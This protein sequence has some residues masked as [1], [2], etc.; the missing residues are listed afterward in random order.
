MV[1][2]LLVAIGLSTLFWAWQ[3][4]LDEPQ[5]RAIL[6]GVT[7]T[8]NLF[9]IFGRA[10]F[11]AIDHLWVMA[12]IVQFSLLVPV[13]VLGARRFFSADRRAAAVLGL[14][15]GVAVC[16]LGFLLSGIAEHSSIAI[17]TFTRTD[18]LLVGVAIGVAPLAT[19]RRQVPI[20]LAPPAFAMML[21][22]LLAAP[23]QAEM[24]T[25]ALG[26]LT[27]AMV[28]FAGV[29]ASWEATGGPNGALSA[30]LDNQFM[31]WIGQR[32]ISLY[33]WHHIF[34][35]ALDG[36]GLGPSEPIQDWPGFALFTV[37]IVFALAAAT[38]SYRYLELPTVAIVEERL[39]HVSNR[40][41][42]SGGEPTGPRQTVRSV[43]EP[44]SLSGRSRQD[45]PT[46]ATD[47]SGG[48]MT[49]G[50]QRPR[51]KQHPGLPGTGPRSA[52]PR[53]GR[54]PVSPMES[55]C[56]LTTAPPSILRT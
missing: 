18:A 41:G 47:R 55:F 32:A 14:A 31:K 27:A 4:Q 50:S 53:G 40:P 24:P 42:S 9:A 17:N 1:T 8:F 19:V 3:D 34:G 49:D 35:F 36:E 51:R 26:I 43:T 7:S 38:A 10:E 11:A 6:G 13:L 16:R 48:Q 56:S 2:S 12:V 37:G 52:G 39:R 54:L 20:R 23:S 45:G 28:G 46:A 25:V 22:L 33:I 15:G 44:G 30:T 21:L 5:L 29:V